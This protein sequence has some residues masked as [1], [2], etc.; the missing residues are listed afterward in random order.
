MPERA[1]PEDWDAEGISLAAQ[2]TLGSAADVAG[3]IS[4]N[5][6]ISG[7]TVFEWVKA[8]A[9]ARMKAQRD[10]YDPDFMHLVEK[11]VM[12]QTLDQVWKENLLQLDYLKKGIGLRAY[13]QKDPL[14]EYKK[15]S[16]VIFEENMARL[17]TQVTRTLLVSNFTPEGV[18]ALTAPGDERVQGPSEPGELG[19]DM[20]YPRNAPCPCG[21]GKKYK[22]C[23]GRLS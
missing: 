19:I 12:L 11:S 5:P 4:E 17:K 6:N 3:W 15:E 14:N 20:N 9:D 18:E 7:Q 21:S 10:S 2:E 16:F 23:H 8:L 13:G 22:H 1:M